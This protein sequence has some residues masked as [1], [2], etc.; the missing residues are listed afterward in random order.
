M[1]P[2]RNGDADCNGVANAIDAALALQ[3]NAGFADVECPSGA[4]VNGD[5]RIDSLDA[6]LILQYTASLINHLPPEEF[7]PPEG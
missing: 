3:D 7:F 5:G 6:S 1:V 4:D 2:H